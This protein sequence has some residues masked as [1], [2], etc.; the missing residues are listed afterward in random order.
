MALG[1]LCTPE[2]MPSI[3]PCG[4]LGVALGWL[5]VALPPWDTQS[6][7]TSPKWRS[8]PGELSGMTAR[9]YGKSEHYDRAGG[10][11]LLEGEGGSVSPPVRG[12]RR[13]AAPAGTGQAVGFFLTVDQFKWQN[14]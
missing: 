2:S 6:K 10:V 12:A 9:S 5:G 7:G 11:A 13:A 1:W 14:R 4:G 8:W 3:W